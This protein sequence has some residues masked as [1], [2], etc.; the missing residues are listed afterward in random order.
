LQKLTQK[1]N[2]S[3]D[4][5]HIKVAQIATFSLEKMDV[6]KAKPAKNQLDPM[7]GPDWY[8]SSKKYQ[9]PVA[10]SYGKNRKI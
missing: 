7:A 5:I 3:K 10:A 8:E 9:I 1:Q 4:L 6:L 2:A